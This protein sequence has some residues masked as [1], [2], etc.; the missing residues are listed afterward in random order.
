MFALF[1]CLSLSKDSPFKLPE[2]GIQKDRVIEIFP[3][4]LFRLQA[5]VSS[6]LFTKILIIP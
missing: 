6:S 4:H 2:L 3:R 5:L 1:V